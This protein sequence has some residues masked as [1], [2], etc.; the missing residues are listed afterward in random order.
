MDEL[1]IY[2]YFCVKER[3]M[4]KVR[5]KDVVNKY[6]EILSELKKKIYKPVYLLMGEESYYIDEISNYIAVNV[7]QESEKAFNQIVLYGKDKDASAATILFAAGR[8][9]MM[10][11]YQVVIVKEAQGIKKIEQLLA[12]LKSPLKSTILVICHKEKNLDKR[13]QF[14][15]EIEKKGTILETVKLYDNE[16]PGWIIDHVKGMGV[17][18]EPSAANILAENIGSDLS[19]IA[20]ELKKLF[21]LLPEGSKMITSDDIEKNIGISKEY[22]T[23]EL[24]KAIFQKNSLKAFKIVDYFSKNPNSS[25][26]TL[27]ISALFMQ[28]SKLLKFHVARYK[29]RGMDPRQLA[30]TTGIEPY[31]VRDYEDAAAR[32]PAVKVVKIIELL[33][34]YD[35]KSKGWNNAGTSDGELMRELV[36]KIIN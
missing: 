12:Y 34:E 7:L 6:N 19:R 36:F 29:Y 21:T 1:G 4:A 2:S 35:M 20:G 10:S 8:P 25:P 33:R 30:T 11:D 3:N 27:T 18:I 22:N 15:K 23:F 32:Y 14:Y 17:A 31:F 5:S 16:I 9:P 26:M 24:N 28:F 13:T